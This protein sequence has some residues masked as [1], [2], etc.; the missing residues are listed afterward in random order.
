[1]HSKLKILVAA[2]V[3]LLVC[4]C[5]FNGSVIIGALVALLTC[6]CLFNSEIGFG[7]GSRGCLKTLKSK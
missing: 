2:Y 4:V 7:E 5:L 3:G 1:M 6:A